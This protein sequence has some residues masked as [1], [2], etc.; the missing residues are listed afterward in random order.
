[1]RDT[2]Q[3]RIQRAEHLAADGSAS[4]PLV[5]FYAA[6]LRVQEGL[7][8]Q[9][10]T[11]S[12]WRPSGAL[13]HDL[14]AFQHHL[15]AVLRAIARVAPESLAREARLLLE[16]EGGHLD[17]MLLAFWREPSDRQF[18]AKMILQP[19]AQWLAERGVAPVGRGLPRADNRCPF[20]AGAPQLSMFRGAS[21]S[22]LEGGGRALQCG[23]CFTTWP[24]R[25]VVCAHCGEE[26]ERRLGY[27]QSPA[28]E[29][30]RVEAC[31]TCSHYLKGVDLTRLGVAVPIVDEV[32]GAPLDAWAREHG[33]EKIEL[34]LVGL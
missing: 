21:D 33:Y 28:F 34:N 8:N 19:Y 10:S 11:L 6:S 12:T 27:F 32:A 14:P 1:M 16:A 4:V 2:W 29:H 15:P 7:Y 17:Q 13:G 31:D 5:A 20:C 24:F 25:R 3:H 26:D 18:F 22:A 23:T 30:L 9:L